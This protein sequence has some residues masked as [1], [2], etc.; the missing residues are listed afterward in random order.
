MKKKILVLALAGMMTLTACGSSKDDNSN[1]TTA[2]KT[3]TT[4][5]VSEKETVT[6]ENDIS[7]IDSDMEAS[8]EASTEE[9]KA[10]D[11]NTEEK[12]ELDLNDSNE[13][14]VNEHEAVVSAVW[15]D[16]VVDNSTYYEEF[17]PENT[18][19]YTTHVFF[20]VDKP[21]KDFKVL[22]LFVKDVDDNG[23]IEFSYSELYEMEELTP[24]KPLVAGMTFNGTLPNNGYMYTDES[25]NERIF[26]L[27]ESGM[28]G[29]LI[30]WQYK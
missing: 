9:G 10:D 5:K 13:T 7:G 19:Q 3:E 29:S 20:S 12:D 2:E 17:V 11:I 23:N 27:E 25:G 15:A 26:V 8:S 24:E 21:V 16:D 1:Y 22:E 28:D 18:S 14:V 4:E 30:V 6:E